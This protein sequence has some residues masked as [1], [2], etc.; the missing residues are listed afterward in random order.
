MTT[1]GYHVRICLRMACGCFCGT[2]RSLS[3]P[4]QAE[5]VAMALVDFLVLDDVTDA[6][7]RSEHCENGHE[8]YD[9]QV[10]TKV[11]PV[12][13]RELTEEDF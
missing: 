5:E 2:A 9:I 7:C 3:D 8:R 4:P 10:R 1:P 11:G 6:L 12:P 13:D